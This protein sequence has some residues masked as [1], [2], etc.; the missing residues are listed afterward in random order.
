MGEWLVRASAI[1]HSPIYRA[2]Q[3][4][5]AKEEKL[6]YNRAIASAVG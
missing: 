6:R 4:A 1:G 5:I 3:G 2:L